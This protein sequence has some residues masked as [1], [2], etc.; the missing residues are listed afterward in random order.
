MGFE[1]EVYE[2]ALL[3][4]DESDDVEHILLGRSGEDED[5]PERHEGEGIFVSL[6]NSGGDL[7]GESG[8]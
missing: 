6:S 3:E 5:E 1:E 7:A 8:A 2:L 4:E